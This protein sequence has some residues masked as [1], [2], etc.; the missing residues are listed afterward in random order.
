MIASG[1]SDVAPAWYAAGVQY[2]SPLVEGI[3]VQRYK[4]FFA[5]VEVAA[6]RGRRQVV[7]AHCANPGSMR[8]CAEPGGRVWLLPAPGAKRKL[9]WTWE[10]AETGGALVCVNT[11]R[12]NQLV[13]EALAAGAIA[14]LRG[15]DEIRREVTVGDSRIDFGLERA[16]ERCFVEVKTATMDAGGGTTAFPDAVTSRGARHVDELAA[17]RRDGHRAVLLFCVARADAARVRPAAEIDPTYAQALRR[18]AA[19]G[20]EVLAYVCDIDTAGLRVARRIEVVL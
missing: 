2:A 6:G 10:L 16:G 15:Y 17:L 7:T 5:D 8:T 12:G 9:P 1:G 11:A 3:L 14:E 13:A 19:E 20:V 18:A 4:R